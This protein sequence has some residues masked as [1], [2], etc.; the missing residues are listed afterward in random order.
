MGFDSFVKNRG[1]LVPPSTK[2]QS[3]EGQADAAPFL[4]QQTADAIHPLRINGI[5]KT[6]KQLS[7]WARRVEEDRKL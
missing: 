5:Q 7:T 3:F 4:T 2:V 6:R 1:D